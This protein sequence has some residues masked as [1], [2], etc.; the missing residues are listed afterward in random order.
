MSPDELLTLRKEYA[1]TEIRREVMPDDPFTLF[2]H[3]FD[4]TLA[5]G[6]PEANGMVVATMGDDGMPSQ[7]TVLMKSL[8]ECGLYF[9]T[10]YHSR[11]ARELARNPR[12]SCLFPW[13]VLHRQVEFQGVV[14]KV[15]R[16]NSAQYFATRPRG[17]Q[18]GAWA[19]RQSEV[20]PDRDTLEQR[21]RTVERRFDGEE[22]P[23]PDFWGGYCLTPDR[24]EFWQGRTSRLH[25]RFVY[26]R[27]PSNE[28]RWS[29]E[30]LYP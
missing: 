5:A 29:L 1:D 12:V 13:L 15:D 2:S 24:V 21:V 16:D 18:V 27:D 26:T 19:S 30:R 10:N 6:L 14:R 4:Q 7:R 28:T 20:L 3:W 25:D 9:Y 22:V 11:K 23:L 17:S 8:D